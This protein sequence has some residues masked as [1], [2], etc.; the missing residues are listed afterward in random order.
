LLA[1][2]AGHVSLHAK[3]KARIHTWE[4]ED[5]V[6]KGV[7]TT[8]GRAQLAKYSAADKSCSV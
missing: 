1:Y 7:E 6:Y 2:D 8:P 5:R 3:V 4:T